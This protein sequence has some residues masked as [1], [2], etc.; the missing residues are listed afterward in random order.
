MHDWDGLARQPEA[1]PTGAASGAFAS[2]SPP[3]LAP[4]ERSA[5]F[6][7]TYQEL[8]GRRFSAEEHEIA[9]AARL[10]PTVHNARWEALH[11]DRPVACEAV[12]AQ[13]AE[14]LRRAN[15]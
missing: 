15:A 5:A 13:A 6:L 10:W 4:V 8:R 3:T 14:R 2:V 7:E 11:G 9:W 12:R 1:A